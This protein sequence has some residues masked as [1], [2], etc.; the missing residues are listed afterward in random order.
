MIFGEVEFAYAE[1]TKVVRAASLYTRTVYDEALLTF[2]QVM[3]IDPAVLAVALTLGVLT[4]VR[5]VDARPVTPVV[6]VETK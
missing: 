4:A 5:V 3:V 6:A 2:V 1:P